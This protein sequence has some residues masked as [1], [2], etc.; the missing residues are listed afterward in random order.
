ME[1]VLKGLKSAGTAVIA[2]VFDALG[3]L[4]P[5]LDNSLQALASG[6]A[7]A[8]PAYTIVG[9]PE[10]YRGGD[11]AKLAAIDA[12]PPGIIAVWSAM[13]AMGVCCFGDLLASAMQARG[14]NA[15]IVDG[16]VRDVSFLQS[17]GMPVIAR[18]KTPAQG[19]GRWR[20]TGWQVPVNVRGAL[21]EGLTVT[22]GDIVVG[23]ADGVIVIPATLLTQVSA[24]VLE[25]V[26]SES[27]AR[28][29]IKQGLPLLAA[30][31][32]YGHL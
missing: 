6:A 31:E 23:D 2:D 17:C 25:W 15:A 21:T 19:I 28:N 9:Q 1:E 22:P 12:M 14:C 8:G 24:K 3:L 5:V 18:Y 32:R 20:V 10:V 16:G 7:F 13:G 26:T 29:E 4:P 27:E 30:L 11:R